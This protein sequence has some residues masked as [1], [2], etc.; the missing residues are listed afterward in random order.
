MTEAVFL[1]LSQRQLKKLAYCSSLS[2]LSLLSMKEV[3]GEAI[4]SNTFF[5]I[6]QFYLES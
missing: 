5:K 1:L 6:A 4:L 2:H 3:V